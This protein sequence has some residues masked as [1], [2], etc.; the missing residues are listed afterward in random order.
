MTRITTLSAGYSHSGFSLS[1]LHASSWCLQ[2]GNEHAHTRCTCRHTC[3]HTHTS[4]LMSHSLTCAQSD[5]CTLHTHI[6]KQ[7]H[8]QSIHRSYTCIYLHAFTCAHSLTPVSVHI[9]THVHMHTQMCP[10]LHAQCMD[11]Y[12]LT[13]ARADTLVYRCIAGT[14]TGT[15]LHTFHTQQA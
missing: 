12:T 9:H 8:T 5:M 14:P 3:R 11:V 4:S 13:N 10:C 6:Y 1:L 15:P 2:L 7:V